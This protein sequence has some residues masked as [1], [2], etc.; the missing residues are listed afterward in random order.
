MV[1]FE[2]LRGFICDSHK[3]QVFDSLLAVELGL[4]VY[5]TFWAAHCDSNEGLTFEDLVVGFI[6]DIYEI[7]GIEGDDIEALV[8]TVADG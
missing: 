4:D 3:G 5:E 8:S 7:V 2:K 6:T 1:S